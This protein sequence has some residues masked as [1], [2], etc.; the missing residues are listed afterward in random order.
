[1]S[2]LSFRHPSAVCMTYLE[3]ARFSLGLAG[4]LF[5]ASL[6]SVVH[7]AWP[8]ALVTY[9]SDTVREL[10]ERMRSAGCHDGKRI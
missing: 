10:D 5:L 8:D 2:R 9:T 6:A 1:M 3:H 7:A 4:S